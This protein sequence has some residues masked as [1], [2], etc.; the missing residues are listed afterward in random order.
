[1]TERDCPEPVPDRMTTVGELGT[2]VAMLRLATLE[3]VVVGLKVAEIVHTAPGATNVQP[4]V[5]VKAEASVPV[6]ATPVTDRFVVPEFVTVIT[7]AA[8]VVLIG[9]LTK[10]RLVGETDIAGPSTE[11]FF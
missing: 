3:P 7:E 6:T 11:K 8:L 5:E 2:F 1:M 10:V 4:F 9:W